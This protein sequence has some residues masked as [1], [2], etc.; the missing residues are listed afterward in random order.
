MLPDEII[1]EIMA[2]KHG[3]TDD[4]DICYIFVKTKDVRIS[5]VIVTT[6]KCAENITMYYLADDTYFKTTNCSRNPH[7]N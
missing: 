6:L 1:M 2:A 4:D 5:R 3:R 7:L